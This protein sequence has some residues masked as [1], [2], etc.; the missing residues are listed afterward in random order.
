M[1][2]YGHQVAQYMDIK[3]HNIWTVAIHGHQVAQYMDSSYH[4]WHILANNK[5]LEISAKVKFKVA[6]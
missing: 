3:L 4:L 1:H 2:K 6:I 5:T